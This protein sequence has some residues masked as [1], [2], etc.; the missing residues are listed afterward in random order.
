MDGKTG[1]FLTS[2]ATLPIDSSSRFIR[3]G[4]RAAPRGGTGVSALGNMLQE[5]A[6]YAEK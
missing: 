5:S 6:P 3:T 4:P 2:V 1:A